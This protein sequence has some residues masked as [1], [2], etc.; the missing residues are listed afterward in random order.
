VSVQAADWTE[1]GLWLAVIASGV[2][3]GLNPGM[4]WPLAVSAGLMGRGRRDLI[5]SLGPLG[6]GHFLAIAGILTPFAAMTALV[7]WQGQIRIC[8]GLLVIAAGAHLLIYR[9]HPRFLARIKPTQLTLWSFAVAIAHGAGLMLL[10]IYLGIC[11]AAQQDVGHEAAAA[12]M[13]GN[14]STAMVVSIVH[15]AAMIVSGGI[16]AFAVHQWLGLRFISKAWFNLDAVWGLSLI[17]VGA[18][19]VTSAA[20]ASA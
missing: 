7:A 4:G 17:L 1:T 15:A 6:A 5:A 20:I 16:V 2:Y 8:A 9:R 13:R 19:G 11:S 3:H 18:I 10:P 14:L 12:L